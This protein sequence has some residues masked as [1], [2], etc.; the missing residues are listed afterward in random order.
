VPSDQLVER[1]VFASLGSPDQVHV[2]ILIALHIQTMDEHEVFGGA[3]EG[4][5]RTVPSAQLPIRSDPL[6]DR[7]G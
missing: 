7:T 6:A 4:R 2:V 1:V 3:F 5:A